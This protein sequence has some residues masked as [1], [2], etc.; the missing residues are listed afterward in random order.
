[1]GKKNR[2]IGLPDPGVIKASTLHTLNSLNYIA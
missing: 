2:L 1:M